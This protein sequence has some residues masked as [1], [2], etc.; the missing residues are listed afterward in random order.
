MTKRVRVDLLT[1]RMVRDAEGRR[2]GRIR[3]LIGEVERPGSGEY[4]VREFH[5]S[6]GGLLEALGGAQLARVIADRLGRKSN[7]RII[8]WRDLDLSDP[9]RPRLRRSLA[10][11]DSDPSQR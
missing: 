5:L 7:R 8:G 3:E 10:E 6:S 11:I 2:V 4:V 9:E 1:G